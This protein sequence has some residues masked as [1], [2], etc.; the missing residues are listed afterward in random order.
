MTDQK[1]SQPAP[2]PAAVTDRPAYNHFAPPELPQDDF[3]DE[4]EI[5]R[6][7][8]PVSY[9]PEHGGF[10]LLTRYEDVYAA[11]TD[12][13]TF[14]SAFSAA[15]PPQPMKF[16]PEDIDPPEHRQYRRLVNTALSPQKVAEH[17]SWIRQEAVALLDDLAGERE[18]D[19]V[20]RFAGPFPRSVALQLI[21]VPKEDLPRISVWT[22]Y[23]TFNPRESEE[24]QQASVDL[25]GYLGELIASRSAE[26]ARDDLLS[27]II[28]GEVNG[29]ALPIEEMMS[30][31]ALLLFGGLHTTTHAIAGSLVWLAEH[32]EQRRRLRED[33]AVWPTAVEEALRYTSP[34]SHLGRTATKDTEIGGCPIPAGSRIMTGLGAANFDDAKFSQPREM[35][36]DRFPNTHAAFGFG[37]HRCV[38]SH[39][40]KLQ[41]RIALQE[42]LARFPDFELVD[43]A[44][45]R[46]AGAEVRGLTS[47][48]LILSAQS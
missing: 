27:A 47:A 35:D 10:Y 20:S 46:Y 2:A 45:L 37:P 16:I 14:S 3:Y 41:L 43:K 23:L 25:F 1:Q 39:L 18:I 48:P 31:V 17:E 19:V 5:R 4:W 8:C 22:E 11:L 29:Q 6:K 42:F 32:P 9:S 24:A 28:H 7:E 30:Y 21:G 40:A 44:A 12:T 33:P 13:E 26:P 38:G 34:S 36:L 15:I